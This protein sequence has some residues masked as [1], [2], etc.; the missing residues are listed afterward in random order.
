MKAIEF[1]TQTKKGIIKIPKKYKELANAFVKII[2][3]TEERKFGVEKKREIKQLLKKIKTKNI[4]KTI[5][6]PSD[7]QKDLRN[8]WK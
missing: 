4:F 2:I 5:Y 1:E 7:W 3:L 6:N 8:E